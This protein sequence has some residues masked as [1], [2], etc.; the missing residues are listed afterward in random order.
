MV[1]VKKPGQPQKAD[2]K[3]KRTYRLHPDVVAIID[4]Q[5]NKVRFIEG[6]VLSTVK[7]EG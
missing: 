2:A 7:K 4:Q 6:L 1:K 3:V 5:P